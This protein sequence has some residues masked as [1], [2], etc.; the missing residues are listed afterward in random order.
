VK[1]KLVLICQYVND[2]DDYIVGVEIEVRDA[3]QW[4]LAAGFPQYVQ[5]YEGTLKVLS[6]RIQLGAVRY[7]AMRRRTVPRG[8]GSG[9]KKTFTFDSCCR[10]LRL[11]A[12]CSSV[13]RV[14]KL[15]TM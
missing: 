7:G 11:L 14:S 10:C 13:G 1:N 9:A 4:L 2:N 3:C 5:L 6:H 8:V 15:I 12:S